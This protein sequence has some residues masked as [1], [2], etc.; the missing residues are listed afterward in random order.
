MV[1]YVDLFDFMGY[2]Y[3]G[4]GFSTMSGHQANLF[5]SST[6]PSSTDY[7]TRSAIG[8][9]ISAGVPPSKIVLGMPLYGRSFEDTE[10][11]KPFTAS[12]NGSQ[13][14]SDSSDGAGVWEYRDL[15]KAGATEIYA[16]D[17]GASYSYDSDTGELISYDNADMVSRKVDY[18][19]SMGLRGVFF[20]EASTDR[21]DE[22]S[23]I[24]TS[25]NKL[26][27]AGDLDSTKNLLFN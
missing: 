23:L 10:L 1:P 15:P 6:N 8:A 22:D 26:R 7:E 20:W 13:S 25:A 19:L 12:T 14:Y 2:D 24:L 17:S 5:K 16:A 11:G 27:A 4:P 9:Y 3:M 18:L 21:T